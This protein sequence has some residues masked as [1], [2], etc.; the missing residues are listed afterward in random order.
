MDRPKGGLAVL[1]FV[2]K[3]LGVK[4]GKVLTDYCGWYDKACRVADRELR[5]AL[6]MVPRDKVQ[7]RQ[8]RIAYKKP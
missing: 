3:L 8:A 1:I 5:Q 7:V 2:S 6:K 4:K